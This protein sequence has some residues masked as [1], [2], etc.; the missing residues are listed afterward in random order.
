[1]LA[2]TS[3]DIKGTLKTQYGLVHQVCKVQT[4]VETYNY[5]EACQPLWHYL[6]N[7]FP[8]VD[9]TGFMGMSS[10]FSSFTEDMTG[11]PVPQS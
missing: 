9:N 7:K 5:I 11:F 10:G 6:Q 8:I 2:N 3:P 1:M 4:T